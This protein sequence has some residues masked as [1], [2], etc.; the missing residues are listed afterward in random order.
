M[1]R[2]LPP[3]A[4]FKP[5]VTAADARAA[6]QA[7]KS[8]WAASGVFVR[9]FETRFAKAVGARRLVAVS[10]GTAAL[11]L[12]LRLAEVEGGEVRTTPLTSP[13]TSHAIVY[14]GQDAF[15]PQ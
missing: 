4:A 11:H 2:A 10:S 12:A 15:A 5:G 3:V 8:G 6:A 9:L 14:A 13:A 7:L 1:E